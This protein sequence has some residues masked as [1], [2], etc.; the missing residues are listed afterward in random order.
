MCLQKTFLF[1]FVVG[2]KILIYWIEKYRIS[3]FSAYWHVDNGIS[4][5]KV[6]IIRVLGKELINI[7]LFLGFFLSN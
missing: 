6:I 7:I 5:A 2:L 4:S 1:S 3:A